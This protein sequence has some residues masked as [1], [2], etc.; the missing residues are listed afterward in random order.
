MT[1]LGTHRWRPARPVPNFRFA[2]LNE[3]CNNKHMKTC[4][5]CKVAKTTDN[6]AKGKG[7]DGLHSWCRLCVSLNRTETY[8]KNPESRRKHQMYSRY[9]LRPEDIENLI[10]IQGGNC[11]LC[12]KPLGDDMVV[13]HDHN[14]CKT[15]PTCG[16]CVRGI[17]H[18]QCNKM[19]G[20]YEYVA[21]LGTLEAYLGM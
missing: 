14:C 9:R 20:W 19:L 8:R 6:F 7:K 11:P 10:E 16:K 15:T 17:V 4:S 21:K 1:G 5:K 12:T 2:L 18:A 3:V 13:D